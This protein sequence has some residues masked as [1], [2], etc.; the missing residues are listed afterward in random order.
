MHAIQTTRRL[1]VLSARAA[2]FCWFFLASL[3]AAVA[4]GAEPKPSPHRFIPAG[5]LVAFVEFDGLD[6]H[7][8]AWKA[9][10]AHGLLVDTPAGSMMTELAK[11]VWDGFAKLV[12]DVKIPG[13]DL[14]AVNDHLM[15]RGF[16]IAVHEAEA[17]NAAFILVLNGFAEKPIR[18]RMERLFLLGFAAP[19]TNK[20]PA[21]IRL[22]GREVYQVADDSAKTLDAV[23]PVPPEPARAAAPRGPW[24]SW[25][26]EGD[27]LVVIA[28]PIEDLEGMPDPSKKATPAAVHTR[29]QA[30]V[31]DVIEGKQPDVATHAAYVSA[32]AEGKDIKGFESD[33]LFFIESGSVKG[34]LGGMDEGRDA[35][36]LLGL[37]AGLDPASKMTQLL[38]PGVPESRD[39]GRKAGEPAAE[40]GGGRCRAA[41]AGPGQDPRPRWNQSNRRPLGFSGEGA[42]DG[43]PGRGAGARK[44]LV[45]WLDQPAFRKDRLP[46]I[47]R[48]ATAFAID[49]LDLLASY[50]K[51]VACLKAARARAGR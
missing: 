33:G 31:L 35:L 43:Y 9:T 29:Y 41:A 46:P 15:H 22:R 2:V 17:G 16:V 38:A 40:A 6:A 1:T 49:S 23:I 10:A 37:S 21:P 12:P 14:I 3:M 5:A 48:G 30:A 11:Q 18:E 28:G 32:L 19:G 47:P 39:Q 24:L 50:Q 25:W 42:L 4:S 26:Y 44:G 45:A 51:V 7:A 27:D 13:A 8:D 34:L 36:A 20:L